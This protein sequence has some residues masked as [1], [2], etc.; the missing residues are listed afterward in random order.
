MKAWQWRSRP[1][2]NGSPPPPP[3]CWF[4]PECMLV[5]RSYCLLL[6]LNLLRHGHPLDLAPMAEGGRREGGR[7]SRRMLTNV[8]FLASSF[9]ALC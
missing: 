7:L 5:T 8:G 2:E 6:R 9:K 4:Y 1:P 3:H